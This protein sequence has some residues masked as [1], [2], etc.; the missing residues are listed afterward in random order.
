MPST[1]LLTANNSI[2]IHVTPDCTNLQRIDKYLSNRFTFYSRSFFAQLI[3]MHAITRNEKRITKP[4][5]PVRVG[6]TITI[7]IPAQQILESPLSNTFTADVSIVYEHPHFLIL[8]KP[9]G[10]IVHKSSTTATTPTLV[11]WITTHYQEINTIGCVDRPGIVH[12]LD[13]DTSGLII[14]ARTN[15]AHQ[16]FT[17][18]FKN[19]HITKTYLALV[20]G[21]PTQSGTIN[22]PISRHPVHRKKM[23]AHTPTRPHSK[24]SSGTAREALTTYEVT[25]YLHNFSLI[26]AKTFTGRTHQIRVHL[27]AIGHPLIGDTVYGSSSPLISHHALHAH[28]LNFTFDEQPFSFTATPPTLFNKLINTLAIEE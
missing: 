11:D 5:T 27:S 21:S 28:T 9:V 17:N 24:R 16:I 20:H 19:R 10:L 15:Y 25:R 2:T 4:S 18:L 14:I 23:M 22:F 7:I 8:N 6:D 3:T 26:T 13:K 1:N 12:R